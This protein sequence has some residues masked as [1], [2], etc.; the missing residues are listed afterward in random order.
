MNHEITL[1]FSF[2][3]KGRYRMASLRNY[4]FMSISRIYYLL[5]LR[6]MASKTEKAT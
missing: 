3:L 4:L 1:F 6:A 2:F 5:S